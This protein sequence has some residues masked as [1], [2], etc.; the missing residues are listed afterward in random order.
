MNLKKIYDADEERRT[1][2]ASRK[3]ESTEKKSSLDANNINMETINSTIKY[4]VEKYPY[5]K[6]FGDFKD[7][8][9]IQ[10]I[11][12]ESLSREIQD[13]PADT[14]NLLCYPK[15]TK[16]TMSQFFSGLYD[17]FIQV[18][19]NK[20]GYLSSAPLKLSFR[21][22]KENQIDNVFVKV[23]M[24][25]N[26]DSNNF[27][28]VFQDYYNSAPEEE[29]TDIKGK[30]EKVSS[31]VQPVLF[32]YMTTTSKKDKKNLKKAVKK[33]NKVLSKGKTDNVW[34]VG[35]VADDYI[36]SPFLDEQHTKIIQTYTDASLQGDASDAGKYVEYLSDL[37]GKEKNDTT[38]YLS[39][40][41]IDS[42]LDSTSDFFSLFC[43]CFAYSLITPETIEVEEVEEP[44]EGQTE[45]AENA[46]EAV[47]DSLRIVDSLSPEDAS[48]LTNA[49]GDWI[50]GG[51]HTMENYNK[52]YD[53]LKNY[54]DAS[55]AWDTLKTAAKEG[56]KAAGK[57]LKE[58]AKK[59]E[60][61]LKKAGKG[62]KNFA[63][64]V[65]S[66]V[67]KSMEAKAENIATEAVVEGGVADTKRR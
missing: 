48:N 58:G 41:G 10:N 9:N 1:R 5:F 44:Q 27:T 46:T 32:E 45:S 22:G 29:K 24:A 63:Q 21:F 62:L 26:L 28:A 51:S 55:I 18:L 37:A 11:W 54:S 23:P 53:E 42:K 39:S 61:G 3:K 67:A 50:M 43:K 35:T 34:L 7:F 13:V 16:A 6:A 66:K 47:E 59:V 36:L 33:V 30:M 38:K 14:F 15:F 2:S 12:Y 49:V 40:V 56:L 65:G 64:K 19:K 25:C 60:E 17:S 52:Y 31:W 20:K 8:E 4:Y 57:K